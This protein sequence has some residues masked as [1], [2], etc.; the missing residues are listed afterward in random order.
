[1]LNKQDESQKQEVF[2]LQN[3]YLYKYTTILNFKYN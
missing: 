3:K 1:M 2:I